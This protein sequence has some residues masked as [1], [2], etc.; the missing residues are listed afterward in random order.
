VDQ[1]GELDAR[2]VARAAVD[3]GK[4]PARLGGLRVVVGE[5]AAAVVLVEG[6]GEAPLV[7]RERPDVE[8]LHLEQV[9]RLRRRARDRPREVVHLREVDVLHV[10]RRV[11]VLDLAARPVDR[12]DA[13]DLALLDRHDRRDLG[14]PAVVERRLLLPRHF[15]DVDGNSGL[16]HGF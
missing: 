9:A 15:L 8:D 16:R 6:A 10:V 5:E 14:V 3:A 7:A 4:V 1:P 13:E 11:V 2:D 12:L